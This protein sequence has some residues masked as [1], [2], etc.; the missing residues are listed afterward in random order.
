MTGMLFIAFFLVLISAVLIVSVLKID[1]IISRILALYLIIVA[2]VVLTGEIAGL[3]GQIDNASFYFVFHLIF[4]VVAFFLWKKSN[5]PIFNPLEV[6]KEFL[7]KYK[8]LPVLISKYPDLFIFVGGILISIIITAVLILVVPP[9]TNDSMTTHMARIGFWLQNGSFRSWD[10]PY[11]FQLIYPVNAQLQVL[12]TIIFSGSDKYA[13]FVQW[14]AMIFA[15]IAIYDMSRFLGW[16]KPA[17]FFA[18]LVW[19]SFPQIILQSSS[20]QNDLAVTAFSVIGICF[21]LKIFKGDQQSNTWLSGLAFGLAAGTKQT[22][23]FLIPG[24]MAILFFLISHK[25]SNIKL[26]VKWGLATLVSITFLGS[27]F[28][29]KNWKEYGNP[30]GPDDIV[31]GD[32]ISSSPS[33]NW[34]KMTVNPA[35]HFYQFVDPSGLPTSISEKAMVIKSSLFKDLFE[36]IGLPLDTTR[37]LYLEKNTFD[38]ETPA[39]IQ[40]DTSWFGPLSVLVLLPA[41]ASQVFSAIKHRDKKKLGLVIMGVIFFF[42]VSLL[43]RGWTLYQSRYFVLSMTFLAP[44]MA[45]MFSN[46]I[47]GKFYRAVI[48]IIGILVL[49]SSVLT[50]PAKPIIREP[51]EFHRNLILSYRER[52]LPGAW[53][54]ISQLF[55]SSKSVFKMN[56][57]QKITLQGGSMRTPMTL[58]MKYVQPGETLGFLGSEGAWH[59]PFFGEKLANKLVLVFPQD[60]LDDRSWITEQQLDWVL[61]SYEEI[62]ENDVPAWLKLAEKYKNWGIYHP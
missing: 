30:F 32:T 7:Q 57:F 12:W 17:S 18:F 51:E 5:R 50:N 43:R 56:W 4:L 45:C 55:T 36:L 60:R 35:R 39:G 9:N 52:G 23:F 29:F 34:I 42:L 8:K 11:I 20:T 33:A 19:A 59:Y 48:T 10:T 40:E 38:Y 3:T 14:F 41:F 61:I 24:L 26:V 21:L 62:S 25:K 16:S 27:V 13:G 46:Q 37:G 15:G 44:L 47:I 6:L 54:E 31:V 58:S 2:Q 49:F 53:E 28:Y 22:W 1:S